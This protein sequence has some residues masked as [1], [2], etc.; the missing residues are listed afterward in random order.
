MLYPKGTPIYGYGINTITGVVTNNEEKEGQKIKAGSLV[1]NVYG[2]LINPSAD[3][4]YLSG[5]LIG[6]STGIE[7]TEAGR[8]LVQIEA[9]TEYR[10]NR[11]FLN[12]GGGQ[13]YPMTIKAWFDAAKTTDEEKEGLDFIPNLV[14]AQKIA[15]NN[16]AGKVTANT[17]A[18]ALTSTPAT[19]TEGKGLSTT[20]IVGIGLGVVGAGVGTYL[21]FKNKSSK[22]K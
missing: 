20:T 6:N 3:L 22:K 4:V 19:N 2:E 18:G 14:D 1:Q 9:I 15:E 8:V 21:L 17:P 12:F 7:K 10:K 11:S 13:Y 5:G 16:T